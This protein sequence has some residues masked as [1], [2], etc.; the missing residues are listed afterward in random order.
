MLTDLSQLQVET[1]D[2]SERDVP[3]IVVGSAATVSVDALGQTVT[4]HVIAIAPLAD[5]LGGDVIYKATIALDTQ[6]VGFR[7]GMSVGVRIE[8]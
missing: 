7:P 2:L 6:P 5:T 3:G 4:G 1:T 8:P